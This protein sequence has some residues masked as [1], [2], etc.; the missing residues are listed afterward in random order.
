[1]DDRKW[2]LSELE[3]EGGGKIGANKIIQRHV[4]RYKRALKVDI[5]LW[6]YT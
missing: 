2:I 4:D 6:P 3:K 1:M 5:S